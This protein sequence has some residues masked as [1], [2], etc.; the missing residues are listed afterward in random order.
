[1]KLGRRLSLKEP[2]VRKTAQQDPTPPRSDN[3]NSNNNTPPAAVQW[4]WDDVVWD[5]DVVWE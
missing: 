3:Q 1:M 5:D 4:M 2:C